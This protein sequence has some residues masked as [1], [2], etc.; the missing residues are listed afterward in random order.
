ML[1]TC[2]AAVAHNVRIGAHPSYRDRKGF[3]RRP[4][5]IP[6]EFLY[7]DV[8]YQIG[9]LMTAARAAGAAVAYVKPHGALYT[10]IAHD[11]TQA[12]AV[13]AAVKD[14]GTNLHLMALSGAPIVGWARDQGLSVIEEAFADRGY[15]PD[16]RLIPR[17]KPG[18]VHQDPEAIAQQ[19]LTIATGTHPFVQA[20]SLC[21]H[22]DTP[23]A[24]RG[25]QLLTEALAREGISVRA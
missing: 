5:N 21:V 25:V 9:A 4:L 11:K 2:V 12:D 13:I 8:L 16:G 22:G 17:G 15:L 18:A 14:A 7:A 23:A 19:A 20:E 1:R 10:T 6:P 24:V 3:G